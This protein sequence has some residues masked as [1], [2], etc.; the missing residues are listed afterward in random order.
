MAELSDAYLSRVAVSLNIPTMWVEDC[1][2]EMR[3]ALWRE[4]CPNPRQLVH[5]RAI[6]FLRQITGTDWKHRL[7]PGSASLD[8]TDEEGRE[9]WPVSVQEA[10]REEMIDARAALSMVNQRDA[11]VLVLSAYGYTHE[12]IGRM[13]GISR[14]HSEQRA[15]KARQALRAGG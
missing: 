7:R 1:V 13:M 8:T 6:D 9:R 5:R 2:Q 14:G 11:Q 15:M 3:L 12:E 4:Q 10:P